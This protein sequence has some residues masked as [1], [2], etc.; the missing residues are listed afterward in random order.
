MTLRKS[1]KSLA[2][3]LA[4]PAFNPQAESFEEHYPVVQEAVSAACRLQ[5]WYRSQRGWLEQRAA[6]LG[7][8]NSS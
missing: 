8:F 4:V 6:A 1:G 2:V 5:E 7:L 3:S